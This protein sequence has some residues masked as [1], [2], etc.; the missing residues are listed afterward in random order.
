ITPLSIF[1]R[2]PDI[3]LRVAVLE[4]PHP[5]QG[6]GGQ[7]VTWF[8]N[9]DPIMGTLLQ[10]LIVAIGKARLRGGYTHTRFLGCKLFGY[11]KR[12]GL[13]NRDGERQSPLAAI[14]TKQTVERSL[15]LFAGGG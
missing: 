3:H 14:L 6:F 1:V 15:D 8:Q 11:L 5:L 4:N 7:R 2:K 10:C 13:T 9:G 12:V